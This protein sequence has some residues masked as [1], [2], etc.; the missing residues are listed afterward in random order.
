MNRLEKFWSFKI[1]K[2]FL[3][4]LTLLLA[5]CE[6]YLLAHDG[7]RKP[8]KL[9]KEFY[10]TNHFY[11]HCLSATTKFAK[12]NNIK[13]CSKPSGME[14]Y[15][16]GQANLTSASLT[17]DCLD[18]GKKPYASPSLQNSGLPPKV[19]MCEYKNKQAHI[20]GIYE[21]YYI[22]AQEIC[23]KFLGKQF[24]REKQSK[25][26][27]VGLKFNAVQRNLG[28]ADRYVVEGAVHWHI[29]NP[30]RFVSTIGRELQ[31]FSCVVEDGAVQNIVFSDVGKLNPGESSKLQLFGFL[32]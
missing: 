19:S 5:A 7:A 31:R 6:P 15:V 10:T 17:L 23:R 3:F 16:F 25:R 30:P 21:G 20:L 32:K 26:D 11:F 1:Q 8:T 2:I 18:S 13:G 28:E 12:E 22:R 14:A 29:M 27:V 4:I 24:T 9:G